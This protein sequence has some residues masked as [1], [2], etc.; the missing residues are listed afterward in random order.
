MISNTAKTQLSKTR[1][2]SNKM[3]EMLFKISKNICHNRTGTFHKSRLSI[4]VKASDLKDPVFVSLSGYKDFV[5]S[6]FVLVS[7]DQTALEFWKFQ[8]QA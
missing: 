4:E 8:F 1:E 5:K 6:S 2:K 7:V 3:G